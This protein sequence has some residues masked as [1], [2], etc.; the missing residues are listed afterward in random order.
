MPALTSVGGFDRVEMKVEVFLRY[1]QRWG[2]KD[3]VKQEREGKK[4][5]RTFPA[6]RDFISL[7]RRFP[8]AGLSGSPVNSW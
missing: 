4:S 1:E 5:C 2:L 6:P 8:M 7:Q 3:E